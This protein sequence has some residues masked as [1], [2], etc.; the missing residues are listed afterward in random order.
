MRFL[1]RYLQ[2]GGSGAGEYSDVPGVAD[3]IEIGSGATQPIKLRGTGVY[4]EHARITRSLGGQIQIRGVDDHTVEVNGK[5]T[6][7][8]ALRE[9][10]EVRIGDNVIKVVAAPPGFDV[11]VNF[12]P[13]SDTASISAASYV[14]AE[15]AKSGKRA[16]SWILFLLVLAIGVILPLAGFYSEGLRNVLRATP[17]VPSDGLW[18]SGPLI[19]GHQVEKIGKNC[20]VCHRGAFEPVQNVS[21]KDC[22]G[23][24][25]AHS[26]DDN[27]LVRNLAKER[28]A[29]CHEE[30]NTPST[31]VRLDQ[32]FCSDCHG[33]LK[34]QLKDSGGI[35]NV[36]DFEDA[37]PEFRLALQV[38]DKVDGKEQW[39]VER[40]RLGGEP[41]VEK[42]NL[43][44]SHKKHLVS[45]G[46]RSPKGR[47]VMKCADCHV[48]DE[49]GLR[50]KPIDMHTHCEEC[51]ILNF[52]PCAPD[53][54]VP[55]ST[56]DVVMYTVE[57]FYRRSGPKVCE[58]PSNSLIDDLSLLPNG[59]EQEDV[60]VA[61]DVPSAI[62]NAERLLF[63]RSTCI[64]C[65]EIKR[66]EQS[67]GPTPFVVRPTRVTDV[68]MPESVFPH[69]AHSS[70][71]CTDCHKV[72]LSDK[73]SDVA[74]PLIKSCRECH[75]GEKTRKKLA[76]P[77]VKCHVFHRQGEPSLFK[78]DAAPQG[79]QPAAAPAAAPG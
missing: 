7:R 55:H 57:G 17:G 35:E 68:W 63:E 43:K 45:K 71:K 53:A 73:S 47:R 18:I 41:I 46:V 52:D 36:K 9:D 61:R 50:I 29:N 42:S 26:S 10:D 59:K 21:C 38:L 79:D 58:T 37:H 69:A 23:T 4:P 40:V 11:A 19:R 2:T 16:W 78:A 12:I 33:G 56:P 5:P 3:A 6:T 64:I 48:P 22:H 34:E 49:L 32:G 70:S 65:H 13:A 28:C 27:D 8:S 44:F 31:L 39:R 25:E 74:M 54:K 72:E 67:T 66:S 51:H 75:G 60:P 30:H 24:I 14:I 20:N 77:C 15:G 62:R 1:I 76:S